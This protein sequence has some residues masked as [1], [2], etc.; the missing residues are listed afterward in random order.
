M[1]CSV[2]VGEDLIRMFLGRMSPG[3]ASSQP[4]NSTAYRKAACSVEAN[5]YRDR[6]RRSPTLLLVAVGDVLR[7]CV[8][9][10][11]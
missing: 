1:V 5:N 9:G 10:A 6:I 3:T 4:R 2:V 11:R 7:S 8:M